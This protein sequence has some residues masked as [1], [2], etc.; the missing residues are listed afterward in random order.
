MKKP[1]TTIIF[2]LFSILSGGCSA[3]CDHMQERPAGQSDVIAL[4]CDPIPVVRVGFIGLGMRGIG[5]VER[6]MYLDSVEVVALCDLEA[7]N[8][9]RAR[10]CSG[11]KRD[12]KLRNIWARRTGNGFA[13]GP[14]SIWSISALTG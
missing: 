8:L 5:A 11:R 1:I 10:P 6:F 14:T 12:P 7:E 2:V 13:N 9:A 3:D 4:A